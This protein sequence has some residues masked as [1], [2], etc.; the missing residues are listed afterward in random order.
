MVLCELKASRAHFNGWQT[1]EIAESQLAC[2]YIIVVLTMQCRGIGIIVHVTTAEDRTLLSPI[3]CLHLSEIVQIRA[4][5]AG[6]IEPWHTWNN[7]VISWDTLIISNLSTCL[8]GRK[9]LVGRSQELP[10]STQTLLW[11]Q[12]LSQLASQNAVRYR[13]S[14]ETPGSKLALIHLCGKQ[15]YAKPKASNQLF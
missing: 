8:R 10:R 7:R 5:F 6:H 2:K 14:S 1:Y 9:H 3:E 12:L 13:R 15:R 4:A 11:K